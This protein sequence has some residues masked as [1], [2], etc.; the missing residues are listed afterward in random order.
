MAPK[1][2]ATH[3]CICQMNDIHI[4]AAAIAA[5]SAH[6]SAIVCSLMLHMLRAAAMQRCGAQQGRQVCWVGAVCNHQ[7]CA[8]H[9]R[10]HHL[11][12]H[13]LLQR[14]G[15]ETPMHATNRPFYPSLP[16]VAISNEGPTTGCSKR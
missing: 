2:A 4:P 16:L 15:S 10:L 13:P 8:K 3:F 6:I 9:R 11:R 5:A 12:L 1:A 7:P 14:S